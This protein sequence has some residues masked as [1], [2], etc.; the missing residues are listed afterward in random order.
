MSIRYYEVSIDSLT[1]QLRNALEKLPTLMIAVL[2]GSVLRMN[3]VR[4]IDVGIYF[5][6]EE[7]LGDIIDLAGILEDMLGLPVDV[8]PLR[9]APPKLRL[10]ALLEG[11]R[12][13]VR[14]NQLYWMLAAQALSE[15]WD[16]ELKLAEIS[17]SRSGRELHA[18]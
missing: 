2:F 17:R 14:D 1:D 13:V 7:D 16:I 5:R 8:V 12:L 15:A 6:S 9:R 3:L 10:K 4:D 11:V 18:G